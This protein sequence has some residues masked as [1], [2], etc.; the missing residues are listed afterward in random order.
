MTGSLKKLQIIFIK[1]NK[2]IIS[3]EYHNNRCK[4]I[5]KVVSIFKGY[6]LIIKNIQL[7]HQIQLI[8]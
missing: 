8:Y 3:K 5:Y 2:I 7:F 4:S 6:T 1:I